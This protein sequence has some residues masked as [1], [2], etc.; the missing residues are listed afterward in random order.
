MLIEG[1]G[2]RDLDQLLKDISVL[3]MDRE[4]IKDLPWVCA[5]I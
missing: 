1:R 4:G 5:E 3:Y 2:I